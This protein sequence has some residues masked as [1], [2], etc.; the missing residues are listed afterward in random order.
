[1]AG[2]LVG[3][4]IVEI[5]AN[6]QK[7]AELEGHITEILAEAAYFIIFDTAQ[8]YRQSIA[9]GKERLNVL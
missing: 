5:K 9:A 4:E 1:M 7:G 6:G 8:F 2:F 3:S